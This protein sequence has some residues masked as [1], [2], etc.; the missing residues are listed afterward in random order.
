MGGVELCHQMVLDAIIKDISYD[1]KPMFMIKQ[2]TLLYGYTLI[3]P[4]SPILW[5]QDILEVLRNAAFF[6]W[7]AF[8]IFGRVAVHLFTTQAVNWLER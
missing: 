5:L 4:K 3:V 6:K 1:V 2:C 8:T 7:K